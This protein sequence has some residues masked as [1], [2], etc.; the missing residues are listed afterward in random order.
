MDDSLWP[1]RFLHLVP[2][3]SSSAQT[4]TSV[5]CGK[6][7]L[8]F[9]VFPPTTTFSQYNVEDVRRGRFQE[10]RKSVLII[11]R[12]LFMFSKRTG[13]FRKSWCKSE[14]H[15]TVKLHGA[16]SAC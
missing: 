2:V 9:S 6:G 5:R 16:S 13:N 10:F 8:L 15:Y 11:V 12:L 7:S 4:S 14:A 3:R 1:I